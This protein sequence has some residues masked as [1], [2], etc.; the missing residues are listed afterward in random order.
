MVVRYPLWDENRLAGS[1][2]TFIDIKTKNE[3]HLFNKL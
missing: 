1:F 2:L 3:I